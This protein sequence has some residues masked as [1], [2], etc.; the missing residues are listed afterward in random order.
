MPEQPHTLFPLVKAAQPQR[1]R[2]LTT[3]ALTNRDCEQATA[4]YAEAIAYC[5]QH[6]ISIST[7][8]VLLSGGRPSKYCGD[9]ALAVTFLRWDGREWTAERELVEPCEL[10]GSR[11]HGAAWLFLSAD[12]YD[13]ERARQLGKTEPTT[14]GGTE[15]LKLWIRRW[16]SEET[17][18]YHLT[19]AQTKTAMHSLFLGTLALFLPI[20]PEPSA[21]QIS[22]DGLALRVPTSFDFYQEFAVGRRLT[23][24]FA[25]QLLLTAL[26]PLRPTEPAKKLSKAITGWLEQ[27]AR[28]Q[29]PSG[30]FVPQLPLT[31]EAST[32]W[33]YA[34]KQALLAHART[35]PPEA[36]SW[37][38][39]EALGLQ[40]DRKALAVEARRFDEV[41]KRPECLDI[42]KE[43]NPRHPDHPIQ[44]FPSQ[45]EE[46][47]DFVKQLVATCTTLR[48]SRAAQSWMFR[49]AAASAFGFYSCF[50]LEVA[51]RMRARG[52]IAEQSGLLVGTC[53][54]QLQRYMQ[55][56]DCLV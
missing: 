40:F 20:I 3:G 48:E 27:T 18:M 2:G 22:S 21:T 35:Q 23:A 32:Y 54:T 34:R 15:G 44:S 43:A 53:H 37:T 38:E 11:S 36:L 7:I 28:L 19:V 47:Y 56:F 5:T 31:R 51:A 41:P 52:L 46:R 13:L 30:A 42:I 33:Q 10:K 12:L 25:H 49:A 8:R 4:L 39:L 45:T 17:A 24:L 50:S 29:V 14:E 26:H 9:V 55:T 1:D 16:D 6:D